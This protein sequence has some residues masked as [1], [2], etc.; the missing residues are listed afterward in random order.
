MKPTVVIVIGVV[1]LGFGIAVSAMVNL[2]LAGIDERIF[3]FENSYPFLPQEQEQTL[4]SLLEERTL[5]QN[6]LVPLF[7]MVIII[8]LALIVV[9][10]IIS[11]RARDRPRP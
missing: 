11:L 6:V 3:V 9:G 7:S 8:G 5:Y 10:A 1:L 4:N 2:E